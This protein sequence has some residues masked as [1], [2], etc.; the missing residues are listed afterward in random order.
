MEA[1]ELVVA[2]REEIPIGRTVYI[3][4]DE[5]D[6]AFF[7][8]LRDH[9]WKL[10]FLD[11]FSDLIAGVDP[12]YYGMIDQLVTS[13]G[14]VFFGCWFSTFTGYVTRLRGYHTQTNPTP[15][16]SQEL[17][18]AHEGGKLPL[19]FYY[20]LSEHKT[21]MHDYWPIKQAFYAREYPS[22]WRQL[23][24]DVEEPS[25]GLES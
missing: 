22:S 18:S 16:L 21:K 14:R 8:P 1:S 19:T 5:R 23:D 20:A 12:H 4:T 9:G 24:F 25:R 7:Q 3:G 2:A 10:L 17:Q 13:R 11:D 15:G 6:K